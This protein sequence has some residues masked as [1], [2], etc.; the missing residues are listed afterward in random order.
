MKKLI[1]IILA[2]ALFIPVM[3][4]ALAEEKAE[5]IP[6]PR[7]EASKSIGRAN[8]AASCNNGTVCYDRKGTPLVCF[9]VQGGYFYA[10]N[11]LTGKV[12]KDFKLNGN[13]IMSHLVRTGPDGKVWINYYPANYIDVYDPISGAYYTDERSSGFHSQDGGLITDEGMIYLGEYRDAGARIYAFN[14]KTGEERYYG[15]YDPDV[16]YFKGICQDE[17][18]IY[19]GSGVGVENARMYRINKETG[20]CD[21][22]FLENTG[23]AIIYTAY[24]INGRIVAHASSQLFFVNA[25]TL[26]LENSIPSGHARHG[27]MGECPYDPNLI[28]HYYS[29]A[30]WEY[31]MAT[32]TNKRI[33][34]SSLT[35]GL[36]WAELPNGDWVL[37]LRSSQMGKVG[38][39]NPKT[40]TVTAYEVDKIAD[41]G[42][43]GQCLE[44]SPEGILYRGGYQNSMGA[45]NINTGEFIFS[46]PTW[47]QNEGQGFLNGKTYFGVYTDAVM[48]RYDPERPWKN[49]SYNH[50]TKYRGY[51]ANPSMVFDIEEGQDRPFVVKGYKDKLYIGTMSGYNGAG[52]ALT[53]L[54]EEDG[55][56]PPHAEVYKGVVGKHSVCGI[57]VKDNLVYISS[58]ARNGKGEF[59]YIDEPPVIAVFDTE[60]KEVIQT[61]VPEIPEVGDKARSLGEISFGPDG[62]LYAAVTDKGGVVFAMDPETF[63]VVKYVS[64][65]P[66]FNRKAEARPAYLR[67]SDSGFLYTTCGWDVM[68]INPETMK[69]TK[70]GVNCSLMT[71]DHNDNL[72]LSK[73]AY[74]SVQKVNQYDRLQGFLRQI[75]KLPKKNYTEEEWKALSVKTEEAKAFTEETDPEL[76]QE[77]I[78]EIKGLRDKKPYVKPQDA[79]SVYIDGEKLELDCYKDGVTKIYDNYTMVPYRAFLEKLGFK[80]TWNVHNATITATKDDTVLEIIMNAK[81]YSINGEA[82]ESEAYSWLLSG[83]QYIPARTIAEELGYEVIWNEKENSVEISKN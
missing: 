34:S 59:E 66:S 46:R 2:I 43:N 56:N 44:I 25:E 79:I 40:K 71:L 70:L 13:Y 38:Y 55:V 39:F 48:Y 28:Y 52:G 75:A 63:E 35:V 58:T 3:P 47:G 27:D 76:I 17:K 53:I 81:K 77:I 24:L 50:D 8:W 18:Y 1:S 31:N 32:K 60:K 49:V 73:G 82:K 11:L 30:I 5:E 4:S 16:T 64:L 74:V 26:E 36:C 51:E 21:K 57:A 14:T 68:C 72:W 20:E 10:F 45:Y 83:I 65:N 80:V 7:H 23:G 9:T 78:R 6:F 33:C 62:L 69:A 19:A 22:T 37:A 42:P 12:V 61:V 67:W 15:P 29:G 54:S 41:A